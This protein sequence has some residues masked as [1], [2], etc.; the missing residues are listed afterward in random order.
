MRLVR[1]ARPPVSPGDEVVSSSH[2]T[3]RDEVEC[4][5]DLIPQLS[6]RERRLAAILVAYS[7]SNDHV[8]K[9]IEHF[10]Y[11]SSLYEFDPALVKESIKFWLKNVHPDTVSVSCIT[12][13]FV[14]CS[15]FLIFLKIAS[16]HF[17]YCHN[18]EWNSFNDCG[19]KLMCY[20]YPIRSTADPT[21]EGQSVQL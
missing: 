12:Q 15:F 11:K 10:R 5:L 17:H 4:T 21:N 8:R 20:R 2:V 6:G 18:K 13:C 3:T 9:I 19:Y 16:F 1:S 14:G 7:F